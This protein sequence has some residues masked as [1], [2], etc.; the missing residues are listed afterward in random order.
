MS[1]VLNKYSDDLDKVDEMFKESNKKS[2]KELNKESNK[3]SNKELKETIS[4]KNDENTTNWYDKNKFNEILTTTDSNNFNHK[5]RIG[6]LRF[7][8]INNL[9]NYVKNNTVSEANAKK[10]TNGLNKTKKVETNGKR[11][12]NSQVTLLSLLGDL[13][14]AILNNSTNNN[15]NNNNNN[16]NNNNNSNNNESDTENESEN[17]SGNESVNK[18]ENEN[19]NENESKNESENESENE[20]ES[21]DEQYYEIDQTNNNFKKIDETK[22]FKDQIDILKEIPWLNDY[23]YIEYSEN[24]KETNLRLFKLKFSHIFNDVND[25]LFKKIFGFYICKIIR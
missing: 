19:K 11:L 8:D 15:N 1:A 6:K 20:N 24:N 10:K 3:E 16:K 5:N 17:K 7:N 22:S 21:D 2:N 12:I 23:W 4:P 18:D 13:G 14:K 25:N 9:I